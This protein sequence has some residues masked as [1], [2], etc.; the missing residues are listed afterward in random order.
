MGF[1]NDGD[2]LRC[3]VYQR[4]KSLTGKDYSEFGDQSH[5]NTRGA[6]NP[7]NVL[8]LTPRVGATTKEQPKVNSNF[9]PLVADPVFDGVNISIPH[10]VVE[11]AGLEDVL[12]SGP[13]M[14]RNTLIILKKWS[15][16]TSLLKEELT[17]IPIWVKLHDVPLQ[18]FEEDDISLIATFIGKPIMLDSYS[19]SMCNDSWGRSSFTRCLIEVNSEADLVDVVTIVTPP[20]V[21]NSNVVTPTVEKANDGFQTVGKKKKGKSTSTSSNS[22]NI[23][24]SNSFSALN[25]KEEE[26]EEV[27]EN[28]YDETA[29]L[30]PNTKTGGGSSFTVAVVVLENRR[31]TGKCNMRINHGMK[32]KEPTYQVVLD[33]LALTTCYPAFLI[34][35]EV[36]VIYMHQFWATINKHTSSYQFKINNKRF[37]V[38]VEVFREILNICPKIPGAEPPKSKK[39]QKKSEFAISS[40]ESLSKK[41]H[42]K[43]KKDATLTKKL[44]TKPKPTKKKA[45]VKADRGKGLN[46]LLEVALSEAAQ[47]KDAIK[48]SKQDSHASHSSGSG[49]ETDFE[50][51]VPDEQHCKTSGLDEGTGT[52]PG[53]PDVPKYDSESEKESWGSS[54]EE[55]DDNENISEDES[56]GDDNEDDGDNDDDGDDYKDDGDNDANDDDNHE[57]DDKNDD[58]EETDSDRTESDRIKSHVLNQSSTE[59]YKEEEKVD[60]EE[61]M[62]EK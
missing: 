28:M 56:D 39:S 43:A 42:A 19:S 13:W 16:S 47:L 21:S 48:Q 14:I 62:D 30:F 40:E 4:M 22:D 55:D 61:K 8:N 31:V 5:M 10:N 52:K 36:L 50:L 35:A 20:I 33:A 24:S 44:A 32:P 51:G 2:A 27:A 25:A 1:F 3:E 6:L 29:N 38:N 11:K 18:V 26:E 15:M 57:D 58:E 41:K 17:H 60:D 59:Y 23:T 46:V 7:S 45:P 53:A 34:T 12:E 54:E 9:H 49:D 37:S